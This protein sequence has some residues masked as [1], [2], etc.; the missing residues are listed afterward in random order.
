MRLKALMRVSAF[1][2]FCCEGKYEEIK[3][4]ENN[5]YLIP[6]PVIQPASQPF[7]AERTE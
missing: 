3:R 2:F 4:I 1:F 6:L 5:I 7:S